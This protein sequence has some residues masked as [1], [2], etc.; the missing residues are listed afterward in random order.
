[1]SGRFLRLFAATCLLSSAVASFAGPASKGFERKSFT[2]NGNWYHSVIAD[3]SSNEITAETV[4]TDRLVS[5]W[6]MIKDT[7]PIAAITGCFFAWESGQPIADVLV[8]GSLVSR[9]H[10]GSV[11]AVD[12]FGK[13]SIFDAPHGKPV[14][15]FPYRYAL[16]GTVRLIADGKVQ[17]NPRLQKFSDPAIWGQASRTGVGL[18]RDGRLIMMATTARVTLSQF[19]NAMK[20]LGAYNAVSL[21]GGGS[22]MLYWNGDMVLNTSRKLC[23]IFVL[24]DRAPLLSARSRN[25]AAATG[26]SK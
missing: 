13:V 9:G 18:M 12:W 8:E 11:L 14:D 4:C 10:I 21:D 6:Q 1:M 20:Q 26:P 2:Y 16:R 17:P 15:W 7:Q 25:L 5:P 24:H 3:M 19:G 22:T 23:N